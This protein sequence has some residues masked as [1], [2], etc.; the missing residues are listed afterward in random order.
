MR[1]SQQSK[2]LVTQRLITQGVLKT[3][4]WYRNGSLC[5]KAPWTL[6]MIA[7]QTTQKVCGKAWG[8]G[9]SA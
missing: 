4:E 7:S 8:S 6:G 3:T 1:R 9:N 2:K 5:F